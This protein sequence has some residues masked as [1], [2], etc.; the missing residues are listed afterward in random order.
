MNRRHARIQLMVTG[1]LW[2]GLATWSHFG[3]D[4]PTRTSIFIGMSALFLLSAI[5][6]PE[7]LAHVLRSILLAVVNGVALTLLTLIYFFFI[8]PIGLLLRLFGKTRTTF[9]P[10]PSL[11]SYWIR[12]PDVPIAPDRY[13][14]SF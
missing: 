7:F 8:T 9:Q 2:A 12:K 10:D 1:L 4:K 3:S 14:R 11:P 6:I 5:L 13:R